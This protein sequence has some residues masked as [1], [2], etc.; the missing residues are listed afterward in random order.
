MKTIVIYKSKTGYTKNYA[1][2]LSKDLQCESY[3]INQITTSKLK[4]YDTVIYG[5]GLYAGGISG[6]KKF[7]KLIKDINTTNVIVYFTGASSSQSFEMDELTTRN[8]TSQEL[9]KYKFYYFRGGFDFDRLSF[10]DKLLMIAFKA[11]IK[12][13][14]KKRPLTPDEKGMLEAYNKSVDFTKANKI[15]PLVDYIR[16][17]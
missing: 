16:S 4:D 11:N 14:K 7:K 3:D 9:K 10:I 1:K 13:N 12:S 8:F 17:L 15:K 5:G 6:L 2:W